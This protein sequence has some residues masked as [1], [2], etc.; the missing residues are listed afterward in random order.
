[1]LCCTLYHICKVQEI[2]VA[3]AFLQKYLWICHRNYLCI[4]I[5]KLISGYLLH[6]LV[7]SWYA[8]CAKSQGG[9]WNQ[10]N[11]TVVLSRFETP[12]ISRDDNKIENRFRWDQTKQG[13]KYTAVPASAGGICLCNSNAKT[14]VQGRE[15]EISSEWS[16]DV[17]EVTGRKPSSESWCH[18]RLC[19]VQDPQC[20]AVTVSVTRVNNNKED[21]ETSW[22]VWCQEY[23]RGTCD[24][25]GPGG[26]T[27]Q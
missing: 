14:P 19:T 16:K 5:L 11:N 23:Y 13:S 22:G 9:G 27:P 1:M 10:W 20:V 17:G 8:K 25:G 24:N 6:L 2:F 3:F 18:N 21:P 7:R 26:V 12:F 4:S 15:R